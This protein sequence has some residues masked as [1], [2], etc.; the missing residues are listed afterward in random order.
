[1]IEFPVNIK[2]YFL[3]KRIRKIELKQINLIICD[4][5]IS[6]NSKPDVLATQNFA[7]L[8]NLCNIFSSN[9]HDFET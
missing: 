7:K 5:L 1:M 2:R 4:T 8:K 6:L 3:T 9:L